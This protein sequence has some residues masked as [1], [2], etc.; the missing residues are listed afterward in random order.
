MPYLH[1]C[2]NISEMTDA[3]RKELEEII[4][5]EIE[6]LNKK[7]DV[8][9]DFTEPIA[10]DT[11]IG[12]VS[13]MDAINNRS[14]YEA[15]ERN[16]ISRLSQLNN[17]LKMTSDADFG[18]CTKCRQSIPIERLRIRPEIRRCAQCMALS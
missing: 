6:K 15:S 11:A 18:I 10:P 8:I 17:I 3:E 16:I 4:N 2:N 13:R 12:R 1:P 5:A 7:L 9:R 14:V